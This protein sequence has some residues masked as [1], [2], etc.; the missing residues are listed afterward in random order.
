MLPALKWNFWILVGR[1]V[2]YFF[3]FFNYLFQKAPTVLNLGAFST[4][5]K[6]RCI[7]DPIFLHFWRWSV[8]EGNTT[9]FFFALLIKAPVH[10]CMARFKWR[11]LISDHKMILS[12]LWW[13]ASE[14]VG[15][16]GLQWI[17][18]S[19]GTCAELDWSTLPYP[20]STSCILP[21]ALITW[22]CRCTD[23]LMVGSD[24]VVLWWGWLRWNK[25]DNNYF[26]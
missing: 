11:L 19:I 18:T 24:S 15:F 6:I 7:P 3:F 21:L 20:T 8:A 26:L 4:F 16:P 1:S 23:A 14:L 2:W 9:I 5:T 25:V 17:P 12:F 13:C 22:E 10:H